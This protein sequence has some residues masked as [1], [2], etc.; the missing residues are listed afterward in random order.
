MTHSIIP[1]SPACKAALPKP[2][3]TS[4]DYSVFNCEKHGEFYVSGTVLAMIRNGN[5]HVED[6]LPKIV[7]ARAG[8]GIDG[9]I[10]SFSFPDE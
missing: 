4:G 6:L 8:K 3:A 1:N 9:M 10:T 2:Q 5:K 7:E